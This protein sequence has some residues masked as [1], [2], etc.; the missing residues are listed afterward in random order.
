[1]QARL[2]AIHVPINMKNLQSAT[3]CRT[4]WQRAVQSERHARG[5]VDFAYACKQASCLPRFHWTTVVLLLKVGL[6][7]SSTVGFLNSAWCWVGTPCLECST[8]GH[9]DVHFHKQFKGVLR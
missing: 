1:M 8:N 6:A 9:I 4:L 3:Y 2:E 7:I 5:V